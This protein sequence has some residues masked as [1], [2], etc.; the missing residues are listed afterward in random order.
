MA[1]KAKE[2]TAKP[3]GQLMIPEEY[4]K[5]LAYDV[6]ILSA[7]KMMNFQC[8]GYETNGQTTTFR[9]V[10]LDSSE[11]NARGKVTLQRVSYHDVVVLGNTGFM[12]IPIP[13]TETEPS[14][15]PLPES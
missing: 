6:T 1:N 10:L 9:D 12:A 13:A 3:D 8:G 11:K 7:K 14:T 2:W 15:S 5:C 4:S